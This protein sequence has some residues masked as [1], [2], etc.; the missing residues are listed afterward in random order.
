M[1]HEVKGRS[2]TDL[3]HVFCACSI[4]RPLV[5]SRSHLGYIYTPVVSNIGLITVIYASGHAFLW[6]LNHKSRKVSI[7]LSRWMW[8]SYTRIR[9]SHTTLWEPMSSTSLCS[10]TQRD[11]ALAI[12]EKRHLCKV[13]YRS[14]H[15][16]PLRITSAIHSANSTPCM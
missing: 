15:R 10:P 11:P 3:L 7:R 12:L 9:Q 13:H 14:Y 8:S 5:C 16:S 6:Y 4:R 2:T 1:L